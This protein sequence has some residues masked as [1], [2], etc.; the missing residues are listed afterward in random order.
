MTL[1]QVITFGR[2]LSMATWRMQDAKARFSEVIE[3]AQHDGPQEITRHGKPR[4]VVVSVTE[5]ERLR[6]SRPSFKEWLAS[7]PGLEGVDL[8][9]AKDSGR[10]VDL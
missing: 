10:E 3:R 4:A 1:F 7:G 8:T 2:R 9:R 5:Y 6:K